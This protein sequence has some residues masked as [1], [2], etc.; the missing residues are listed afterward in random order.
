MAVPAIASQSGPDPILAAI[1]AHKAA[2]RAVIAENDTHTELEKELPPEKR[3][4]N[5]NV[6]EELIIFDDDPRWIASERAMHDLWDAEGVAAA[7]LVTVLPTTVAGLI[8]LLQYAVEADTDGETWPRD[9]VAGDRSGAWHHLLIEN[10][11]Q[12]L[13]GMIGSQGSAV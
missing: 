5:V 6:W 11:A 9:L 8:A 1:E 13:P 12:V 7:E 10:I 2:F 4:S 3:Y